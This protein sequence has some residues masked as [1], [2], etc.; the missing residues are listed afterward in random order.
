MGD[1][2]RN[3]SAGDPLLG[4]LFAGRYRL[5]EI[6]GRGG[7]AT[8]YRATDELLGRPVAAKILSSSSADTDEVRRQQSEVR[9][10][11]SLSHPGLVTLFDAGAADTPDGPRAF[12]VMELVRGV[13]LRERMTDGPMTFREVAGTGADL[14]DSLHYIHRRDVVH[15]DI[16]PGNILLVD[17]AEDDTGVRTKLADFGIARIVDG[18]HLTAT[19]AIIGTVSYLSPEQ[20]M[21]EPV[22]PPA[23]IYALGLVLLECLTGEK[24]FPGGATESIM[25]R[26]LRDPEVPA[27]FSPEWSALLRA[28]TARKPEDRPSAR[29]VS[30][31]LR[32]LSRPRTGFRGAA[33]AATAA[34]ATVPGETGLLATALLPQPPGSGGSADTADIAL[35]GEPT[36]AVSGP[37]GTGTHSPVSAATDVLPESDDPLRA[38]LDPEDDRAGSAVP[39]TASAQATPA[40]VTSTASTPAPANRRRPRRRLPALAGTAIGAVLLALA[41]WGVTSAVSPPSSPD[42]AVTY[43]PVP[44]P[45]GT[46]LEQL[47]ESVESP[48]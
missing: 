14:A 29:Q 34:D 48:E 22:G 28:M 24:A 17:P 45:L 18:S 32:R 9:L 3:A 39:G 21:G 20:A 2:S 47:Q 19:G 38:L 11:A 6:A 15:R 26:V 35:L 25:A 27:S 46:S 31:A 30:D 10:L 16:K 44:G 4:S 23:D 12:L 7:M 33:T 13:T 1:E 5:E 43:P 40:P 37:A 8:V 42:P 36:R 41:A